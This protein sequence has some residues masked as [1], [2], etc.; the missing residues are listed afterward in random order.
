MRLGAQSR[1]D[2]MLN[3]YARLS[4]TPLL[5]RSG[6]ANTQELCQAIIAVVLPLDGTIGMPWKAGVEDVFHRRVT[7]PVPSF[8]I[9]P[10]EVPRQSSLWLAW[11]CFRPPWM[12]LRL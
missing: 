7:H 3:L 5:G 1:H 2:E 12:T 11:P 10:L 8:Q 9:W 4:K 6:P